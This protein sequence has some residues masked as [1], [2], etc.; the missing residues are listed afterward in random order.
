M[1]LTNQNNVRNHNDNN[2]NDKPNGMRLNNKETTRV[3]SVNVTS[4][5]STALVSYLVLR[6][7]LVVARCKTVLSFTFWLKQIDSI[8]SFKSN[9]PCIYRWCI[10]PS[11]WPTQR[12][13]CSWGPD[14][15][16]L[17]T[18]RQSQQR[19]PSERCKDR[20]PDTW[21]SSRPPPAP[22]GCSSRP[23]GTPSASNPFHRAA[24]AQKN[25]YYSKCRIRNWI[26]VRKWWRWKSN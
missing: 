26:K 20:S 9:I 16:N 14:S 2:R 6:V 13:A 7:S 8:K 4:V 18:E 22:D 23:E 25:Q 24:H 5:S 3:T 12:L 21:D 11:R 17:A 1:V 19:P 10:R 15:G